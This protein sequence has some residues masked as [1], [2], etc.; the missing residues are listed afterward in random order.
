VN[1][2]TEPKTAPPM[3]ERQR[4][5]LRLMS[6]DCVRALQDLHESQI[7]E[8]HER[9]VELSLVLARTNSTYQRALRVKG[10]RVGDGVRVMVGAFQYR[11]A[12]ITEV[13]DRT[14]VIPLDGMG[15]VVTP[16]EIEMI[17]ER[18]R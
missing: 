4:A 2:K 3:S 17:E 13:N 18:S 6:R 12:C 7:N 16:D 5:R 1:E 11:S 9:L 10:F 15:T 8:N 14:V